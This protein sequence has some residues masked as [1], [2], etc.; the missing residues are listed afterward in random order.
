MEG[1]SI[2]EAESIA[3]EDELFEPEVQQSGNGAGSSRDASRGEQSRS[4][5]DE[6]E[7]RTEHYVEKNGFSILVPPATRRWE[8]QIYEPPSVEIILH[9]YSDDDGISYFVRFS[10]GTEELVS[11]VPL[12]L[13]VS[14]ALFRDM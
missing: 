12:M 7:R 8:Y 6:L 1:E 5:S 3:S 4:S 9:E 11:R 10:D 13:L 2:G 14:K